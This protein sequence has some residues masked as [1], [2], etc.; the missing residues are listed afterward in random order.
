MGLFEVEVAVGRMGA[1]EL[2]PVTALV[3]TGAAHSVIPDSL[4]SQHN[5]SPLEYRPFTIDDGIEVEFGYGMALF[6]IDG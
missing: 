5:I 1:A 6:G 3:N 2:T 4:L